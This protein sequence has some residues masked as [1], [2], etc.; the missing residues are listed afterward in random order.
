MEEFTNL[1]WLKLRIIYPI[2]SGLVED[3]TEDSELRRIRLEQADSDGYEQDWGYLNL[4]IDPIAQLEPCCMIPKGNKNKK[5][6]TQITLQSGNLVMAVGK[7]EDVYKQI[8]E[9]LNALK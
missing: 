7:P 5:F 4:A 2:T 6:Y 1:Q 8:E 9:Y 3:D